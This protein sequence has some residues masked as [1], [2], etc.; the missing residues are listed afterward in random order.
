MKSAT[1]TAAAIDTKASELDDQAARTGDRAFAN[2]LRN[3]AS[4]MRYVAMHL[5]AGRVQSALTAAFDMETGAR[6]EFPMDLWKLG[7]EAGMV[8]A[9][10]NGRKVLYVQVS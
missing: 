4:S 8:G 3:D 9:R 2:M 10:P 5:R 1:K 7:V 6:D